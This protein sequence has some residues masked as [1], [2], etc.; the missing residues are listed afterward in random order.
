LARHGID[1]TH[2]V[3]EPGRQFIQSTG[4]ILSDVRPGASPLILGHDI[5]DG[6]P[7]QVRKTPQRSVLTVADLEL[8]SLVNDSGQIQ[9]QLI[10][11]RFGNRPFTVLLFHE[12][13]DGLDSLQQLSF[14][15]R[16][17]RV[18]RLRRRK[19]LNDR[20]PGLIV[21]QSFRHPCL[22]LLNPC[23]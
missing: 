5:P 2:Q 23:F 7:P 21:L 3:G 13:I 6:P 1:G 9:T 20:V 22:E 16:R 19:Q 10:G 11:Q 12:L 14:T 15:S 17:R 8:L 4:V 18:E